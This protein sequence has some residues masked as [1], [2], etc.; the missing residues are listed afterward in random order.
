MNSINM[1]TAVAADMVSHSAEIVNFV[2]YEFSLI[3]ILCLMHVTLHTH[4][5]FGQ[6]AYLRTA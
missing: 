5:A 6:H 2:L 1:A 4:K 3:F